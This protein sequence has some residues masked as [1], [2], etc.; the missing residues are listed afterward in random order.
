MKFIHFEQIQWSNLLE[1]TKP[2]GRRP[3]PDLLRCR[4]RS[5]SLTA[6][7]RG[8]RAG[9]GI[10]LEELKLATLWDALGQKHP[11][12]SRLE[13]TSIGYSDLP[14]SILFNFL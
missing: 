13:L 12:D 10:N 5:D 14:N 8:Y 6:M 7:R 2:R 11:E 4:A 3:A 9:P 1:S